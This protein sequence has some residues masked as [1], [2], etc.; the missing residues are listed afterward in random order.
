MKD[1]VENTKKAEIV[2]LFSELEMPPMQDILIVGRKAPI[3]YEAARKIVDILSPGQYEV[4]KVE[5]PVIEAI[6]IRKTLASIIPKDKLISL[7]IEGGDKIANEA[8]IIK[9]QI[10]IVLKVSKTIEL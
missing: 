6:A 10:D 5:H 8:S 2:M 4:I 3:G 9:G 1:R 7:I